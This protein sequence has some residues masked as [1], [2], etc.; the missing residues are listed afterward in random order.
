MRIEFLLDRVVNDYR[1]GTP[2]EE[3]YTAGQIVDLP[4]PSAEHWISRRIAKAVDTPLTA[5]PTP[6]AVPTTSATPEP[7]VPTT[8]HTMPNLPDERKPLQ[9]PTM[10]P[11]AEASKEKSKR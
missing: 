1:K 9:Q 5:Q 11:Q 4:G 2:E 3:H 6:P 10:I 7:A 8:G